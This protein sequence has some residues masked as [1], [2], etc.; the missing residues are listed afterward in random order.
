[1]RWNA[2]TSAQVTVGELVVTAPVAN[3]IY[4]TLP[5]RTSSFLRNAWVCVRGWNLTQRY[6]KRHELLKELSGYI[7]PTAWQKLPNYSDEV[8]ASLVAYYQYK[9]V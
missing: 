4:E 3:T 6:M 9:P 2:L 8:L 7:H 1:M 5:K